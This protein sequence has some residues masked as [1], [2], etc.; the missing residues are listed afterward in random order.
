M[1]DHQDVVLGD[2][3]VE[4]ENVGSGGDAVLE[5]RNGILWPVGSTAT[6]GVNQNRAWSVEVRLRGGGKSHEKEKNGGFEHVISFNAKSYP[7]MKRG[8]DS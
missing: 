8:G 1:R 5:R 7:R 3:E 4:F 6:M 2:G